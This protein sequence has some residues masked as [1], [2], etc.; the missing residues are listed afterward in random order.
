MVRAIGEVEYVSRS[1]V[2]SD[3]KKEVWSGLSVKY[4]MLVDR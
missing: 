3:R 2:V 1:L 4:S